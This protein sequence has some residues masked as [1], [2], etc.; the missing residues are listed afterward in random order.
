MT[1]AFAKQPHTRQMKHQELCAVSDCSRRY[2]AKGYCRK[3]WERMHFNG[4]TERRTADPNSPLIARL[5]ANSEL[6]G[7]CIV[8]TGR[9]NRYGYGE[10]TFRGQG[11][12]AHRAAYEV[13]KGAIP[14]GL[15]ICH[16]CDNPP[17]V[18]PDHLRAGTAADNAHDKVERERS[19]RGVGNA[20]AKLTEAD[21]REIRLLRA[22][23]HTY[24]QLAS[25]FQVGTSTIGRVVKRTHWRHV[26]G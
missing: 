16:S 10:L 18:N 22:K 3:H 8:W 23:G 17:C 11:M 12:T 24:G 13:H 4:T 5:T 1:G 21:V 14:E 6:Q 20:A 2:Y 25:R 26:D 19:A 9:I 7:E 15:F